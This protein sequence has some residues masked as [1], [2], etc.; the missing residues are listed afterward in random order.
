MDII[1]AIVAINPDAQ[2]TV[3][4]N[5]YDKIIWGETE[6]ISKVD[7]QAKVEELKSAYNALE[8]SRKRKAEYPSIEDLMV[9]LAEKEAGDSTMWDEVTIKRQ[10]IKLKYPKS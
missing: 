10:A 7:I 6:V 9:A 2:V 5:D 4:G 8:Y 3:N 1:S